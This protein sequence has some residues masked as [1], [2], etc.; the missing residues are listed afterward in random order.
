ML[1]VA[2]THVPRALTQTQIALVAVKNAYVD[3]LNPNT[4]YDWRANGLQVANESGQSGQFPPHASIALLQFDISSLQGQEIV[5]ANLRLVVWRGCCGNM[6]IV[7]ELRSSDFDEQTVTYNTIIYTPLTLPVA[8]LS[9]ISSAM[10]G[11]PAILI[12]ITGALL[13]TLQSGSKFMTLTIYADNPN[14]ST[15]LQYAFVNREDTYGNAPQLL[16]N[17]PLA[18][19]QQTGPTSSTSSHPPTV[20]TSVQTQLE[21]TMFTSMESK[22]GVGALSVAVVL[23][24]VYVLRLKTKKGREE[25][26]KKK[27]KTKERSIRK[28]SDITAESLRLGF[29]FIPDTSLNDPMRVVDSIRGGEGRVYVCENRN[30]EKFALKTFNYIEDPA[31]YKR[32]EK[33]FYNEAALWVG[34]GRHPN[35]VRALSF[36]KMSDS[37]YLLLEFV[38]GENLRRFITNERCD[39]PRATEIMK[40]VCSGLMYA[41]SQ[42]VVHGDIKPEN[43]LLDKYGR[44]KVTDFGVSRISG[45]TS[46]TLSLQAT[47]TLAYMSPEQFFS[48][49]EIDERSDI[50]SFGI[51]LYEMLTHKNPLRAETFNEAV[52]A[53]QFRNLA[54]PSSLQKGI[55]REI[56][57]L[58]LACTKRNPKE[59]LH[60]FG[61]VFGVLEIYTS[62]TANRS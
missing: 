26:R 25:G 14:D 42:G 49:G 19:L 6:P 44:A 28:L 39:T 34:L 61:E 31:D 8:A 33:R 10:I 18:N 62:N 20:T 17:A 24:S 15:K 51:V 54:P 2:F 40:D 59:R 21:G 22:F 1:L 57:R 27:R 41:H 56:D 48:E 50:Y 3:S 32:I 12:P 55:P 38:E 36:G 45:D 30:G 52:A 4:P 53:R 47:G 58:V 9:T 13:Q 16:V 35:I 7:V 23:T 60:H 11:G 46:S 5:S 43:I 29:E 37:P